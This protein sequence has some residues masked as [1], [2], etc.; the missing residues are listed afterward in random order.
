MKM[1]KKL[2][3]GLNIQYIWTKVDKHLK[4]KQI[5]WNPSL[6]NILVVHCHFVGQEA[7]ILD[8]SGK[9]T[10]FE[11]LA[12]QQNAW[13]GDLTTQGAS[14]CMSEHMRGHKR[15]KIGWDFENICWLPVLRWSNVL[16]SIIG[17][18]V[19]TWQYAGNVFLIA[20]IIRS[21]FGNLFLTEL[22]LLYCRQI[23]TRI[24]LSEE[25][26]LFPM[27]KTCS[28]RIWRTTITN[29]ETWHWASLSVPL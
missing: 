5:K 18:C 7:K 22:R 6:I 15:L 11:S 24:S 20:N 13:G 4:K 26:Q 28:Y 16:L 8:I 21:S 2:F 27:I 10:H 17:T 9:K 25:K 3:L 1:Q 23:E 29:I 14:S 12:N 19:G